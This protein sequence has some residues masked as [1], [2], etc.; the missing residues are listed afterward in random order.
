[1]L[2]NKTLK[3]TKNNRRMDLEFKL[4]NNTKFIRV[5]IEDENGKIAWTNPIWLT[6]Y[7]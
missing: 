5:E 7:N 4:L 2:D 3:E 6:N 1:M